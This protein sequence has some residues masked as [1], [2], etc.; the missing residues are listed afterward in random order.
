MSESR[1]QRLTFLQF[2][3]QIKYGPVSD[4]LLFCVANRSLFVL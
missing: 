3:I 4:A 2:V 1:R